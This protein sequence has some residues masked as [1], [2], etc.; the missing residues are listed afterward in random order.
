M[1]SRWYP[2]ILREFVNFCSFWLWEK[3][4]I[5]VCSSWFC[6]F[7]SL[8]T[9]GAA[10]YAH[11]F[12]VNL[13]ISVVF[14]CGS[15]HTYPFIFRECINFCSF[16]LREQLFFPFVPVYS[17]WIRRFLSLVSDYGSSRLYRLFL[18]NLSIPV[19][20]HCAS[21]LLYPFIPC[22]SSRLYPFFFS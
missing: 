16:G 12:L 13:S 2:F 19:A 9:L 1:S 22:G 20:F 8:F 6:R 3:P 17:S 21:I 4:H 15:G 10:V 11:L 5:P 7:L 18:V 14:H